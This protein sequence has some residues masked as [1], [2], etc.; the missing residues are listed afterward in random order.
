M[1][2]RSHVRGAAGIAAI[3]GGL[4]AGRAQAYVRSTTDAG[5]KYHWNETCVPVTIY[6]NNFTTTPAASGMTATDVIK[7]VTA[8]AHAWSP[9]SVTTCPGATSPSFEIV[10]SV[11]PDAAKPPKVAWD[12]KNTIIFRTE[13]W[14]MSGEA[15]TMDYDPAGLAV[16]TVT[17]RGDGHIVDVDM[18]V[19]GVSQTWMNLD[20][21]IYPPSNHDQGADVYDLQNA[22][23]HEFGHFIGLAHTCYSPPSTTSSTTSIHP[24][25]NTGARVPD[26]DDETEAEAAA[27]MNSVMWW[28]TDPG[29]IN[30]R[31]L[32]PDD[33][34][35]V[36]G[37]YP[38]ARPA[39]ACALDQ[40][41]PG[42]AVAPRVARRWG[43]G[44]V[45][46]L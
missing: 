20:P 42:C 38:Q 15:N 6:L 4:S 34:N 1:A 17:A 37:I 29:S 23:T 22:L 41:N 8:A 7:S 40:V 32:Y 10:P 16:T 9:D 25:D 21:G 28:Q 30:K 26:C 46:S 3:L 13:M 5:A 44:G 14:S 11:A 43:L 35:A 24:V 39:P 18:E 31:T 45:L 12:G 2:R 33:I 36:C 19:N 27:E